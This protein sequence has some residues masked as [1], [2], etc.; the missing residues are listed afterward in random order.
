MN[1]LNFESHIQLTMSNNEQLQR[2]SK[3][4]LLQI[5]NVAL[6]QLTESLCGYTNL[7]QMSVPR[8]DAAKLNSFVAASTSL[9]STAKHQF[10]I[11]EVNF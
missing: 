11:P 1:T 5:L 7:Q 3:E 8:L 10:A 9:D 4:N 6:G 2:A